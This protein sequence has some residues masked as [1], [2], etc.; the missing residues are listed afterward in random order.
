M[1]EAVIGTP[2]AD[3]FQSRDD[4]VDYIEQQTA[5][6]LE[7]ALRRGPCA[8]SGVC[9]ATS[10][11]VGRD[12]A[13]Y[14]VLKAAAFALGYLGPDQAKEELHVH[15]QLRSVSGLWFRAALRA[16]VVSGA[17]GDGPHAGVEPHGQK[18]QQEIRTRWPSTPVDSTPGRPPGSPG[19]RIPW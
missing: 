16:P 6:A 19:E 9:R 8:S 3:K 14:S 5:S 15:Q 11:P 12:S 13:G 7:K 10:G 2:P 18:L 1:S 17:I 4:L